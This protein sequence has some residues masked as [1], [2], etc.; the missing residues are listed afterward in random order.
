MNGID[1][2][3]VIVILAVTAALKQE[4]RWM[5]LRC[6]PYQ[7][8]AT[9]F[10]KGSRNFGGADLRQKRKWCGKWRLATVLLCFAPVL[11]RHAEMDYVLPQ[12]GFSWML[13][14]T[15]KH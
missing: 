3:S 4:T 14:Y 13:F 15:L 2:P 10:G 5:D 12:N 9:R 6:R 8:L 1:L 7:Q 11:L